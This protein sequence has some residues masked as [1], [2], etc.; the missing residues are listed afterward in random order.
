MHGD[1]REDLKLLQLYALRYAHDCLPGC[2]AVRIKIEV[3]DNKPIS[4]PLPKQ[5]V[6][7]PANGVSGV[8]AGDE[9]S[10]CATDVLR[11]L[12]DVGHHLTFDAIQSEME[13]RDRLWGESTLRRT[14]AHLRS[15]GRITN[16]QDARPKGYG[17]PQWDQPSAP[18]PQEGS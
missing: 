13:A 11:T 14:L 18:R 3:E 15:H 8:S 1:S 5:P 9:D 4:V 7:A 17:L 10:D 6:R 2:R 16:R 12:A